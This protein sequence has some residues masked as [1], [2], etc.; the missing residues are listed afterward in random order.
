MRTCKRL[1]IKTVAVYSEPDS[2][3]LHVR[4]ADESICVGPAASSQSYLV[5]D[6]ILD[7]C[8]KTGAQAVH[9][10]YGFLSENTKFAGMLD[11]NGIAFIGPGAQAV[12]IMGDKLESKKIARAAGV[13]LV[14]CSP[15][16]V[17]TVEEALKISR[18]IGYPVML[19]ELCLL[20]F[21][22]VV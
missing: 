15:G 22:F 2:N 4:S 6:R 8:K 14:P 1:G 7:A 18:E 10:G 5:M 20:S 3:A 13:N 17:K 16:E 21:F 9:P 12:K 19:S 11:A